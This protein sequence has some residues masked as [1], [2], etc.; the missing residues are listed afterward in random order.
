M[1]RFSAIDLG[2]FKSVAC[3]YRSQADA[4]FV[5]AAT[6]PKASSHHVK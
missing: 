3:D 6:T 4:S 2:K 5:T 1:D